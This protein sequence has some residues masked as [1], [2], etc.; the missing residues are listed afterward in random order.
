MYYFTCMNVPYHI[1]GVDKAYFNRLKLFKQHNIPAKILTVDYNHMAYD[2]LVHQGVEYDTINMYDYFQNA[3][4]LKESTT[5]DLPRY[6]KEVLHYQ[7]DVVDHQLDIQVKSPTGKFLMYARFVT[8]ERKKLNFVNYISNIGTITKHER[9]DNRGFLSSVRFLGPEERVF[10]EQYYNPTGDIVLEKHFDINN[11][12]APVSILLMQQNGSTL[13][14]ANEDELIAHFIECIYKEG[15]VFIIDRPYEYVKPFAMTR[16]SIPAAI[17]MHTTHLPDAYSEGRPFKWPYNFLGNHIDRFDALICSTEEQKS[18]LIASSPFK[19][20][21]YN[22]PVGMIKD[23]ALIPVTDISHKNP[24]KIISVARYIKTKQIDH[25]IKLVHR[26]K[27]HFPELTLDIYGFGGI[28][29]VEDDLRNLITTL[30]AESYIKLKGYSTDLSQAYEESGLSLITSTEEGFAL[31]LLESYNHNTPVIGYDVKYGPSEIIIN[32]VNGNI[33][34]F[35]DEQALYDKVYQFLS[36]AEL[37]NKYYKNC[38]L[39]KQKYSKTA[40]FKQWQNLIANFNQ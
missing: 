17:F 9:Y 32:D 7:L 19:G 36:D 11:Q 5:L 28:G 34:P 6:W 33:V 15:D 13:Y 4:Y 26:L 21:I 29:G 23:E 25:Q 22:I 38:I 12:Q 2:T 3:V 8:T 40:N 39:T 16:S 1:T 18:D 20:S 37:R 27:E 31:V 24:Y 35:N 14:F 10:L 30:G